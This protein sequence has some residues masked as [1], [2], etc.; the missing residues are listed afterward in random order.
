MTEEKIIKI[1]ADFHF[2]PDYIEIEY[3]EYFERLVE[4]F[5][6]RRIL[7][8][9]LGEKNKLYYSVIDK[10]ISIF[11]IYYKFD[12]RILINKTLYEEFISLEEKRNLIEKIT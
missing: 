4:D 8:L 9:Y 5:S 11:P 12:K 6:P 7:F 1:T 2:L 3:S 10:C